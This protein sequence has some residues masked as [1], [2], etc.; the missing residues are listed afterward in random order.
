MK[1][2]MTA[3]KENSILI[4][5]LQKHELQA[6]GLFY[7]QYAP[8]FYGTIKN[9]LYREE[10][11]EQTTVDSFHLIWRNIKDFDAARESL[12][13]WSLKLVKK[14]ISKQKVNLL[15]K[16]IFSCQHAHLKEPAY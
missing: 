5:G 6:Y 13:L 7:D 8:L 9:S 4:D 11:S 12:L 2:P 3:P 14:E 10:L 15:L 1:T 16:E